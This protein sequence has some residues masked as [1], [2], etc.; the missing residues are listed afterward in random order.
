M[1]GQ[2]LGLDYCFVDKNKDVRIF[3]AANTESLAGSV[4]GNINH[5]I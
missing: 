3:L 5:K 1:I 4:K 2:K